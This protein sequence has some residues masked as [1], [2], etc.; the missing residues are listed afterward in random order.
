MR[1]SSE[2]WN[3]LDDTQKKKAVSIMMWEYDAGEVRTRQLP[4][5]QGDFFADQETD[6]G[7]W[8]Q[9]KGDQDYI[10]PRPLT[11]CAR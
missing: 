1:P 5:L 8:A 7:K 4:K 10:I 11:S 6:A 3:W 2:M 9:G